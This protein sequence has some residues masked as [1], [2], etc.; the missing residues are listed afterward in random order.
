[1]SKT[2]PVRP[3]YTPE[4]RQR[5]ALMFFQSADTSEDIGRAVGS[6][7]TSVLN[8]AKDYLGIPRNTKATPTELRHMYAALSAEQTSKDGEP[9]ESAPPARVIPDPVLAGKVRDAVTYL[10]QAE[11]AINLS[12]RSGKTRQLDDVHLMA[13]LALRTL[14]Q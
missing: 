12:M 4:E 5:Y 11:R 9:G 3:T 13:L 14:T 6:S 1:M 8:W 7:G 10:Q 2:K